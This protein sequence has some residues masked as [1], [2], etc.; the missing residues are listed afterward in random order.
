MLRALVVA[1]VG[2]VFAACPPCIPNGTSCQFDCST[3]ADCKDGKLCMHEHAHDGNLDICVAPCTV[4]DAG[5][6]SFA[7]PDS[8]A[9]TACRKDD[10][11][12]FCP[13]PGQ[14]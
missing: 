10:G 6:P 13:I 7:C 12:I 14:R 5:F 1:F 4:S 8:P 2:V 9:G 3:N 11:S